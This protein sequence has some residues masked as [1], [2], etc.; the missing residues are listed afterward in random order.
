MR[1]NPN[2]ANG[3][4]TIGTTSEEDVTAAQLLE[5]FKTTYPINWEQFCPVAFIHSASRT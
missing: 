1:K 4:A 5:L 2:T 3:A